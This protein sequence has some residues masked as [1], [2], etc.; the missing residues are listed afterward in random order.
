MDGEE[1]KKTARQISIELYK[2]NHKAVGKLQN[3]EAHC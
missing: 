1:I 3:R 2:D